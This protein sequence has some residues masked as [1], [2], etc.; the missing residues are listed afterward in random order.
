MILFD[1]FLG[2]LKVGCFAFG[3]AYGA[4]PLIRDIVLSY[5]WLSEESLTYMIAISESSPIMVNVA[6]YVG[7][8]QAGFWG[9]LVATTAVV[10][11]AFLII[12]L[13][14]V[15]LNSLL[16]RP[17][18]QAVL[19]GLKPCI[20]GIILVTGVCMLINSCIPSGQPDLRAIAVAALLIL[21]QLSYSRIRK[22][23]LTP[24]Q[25]ILVAAL[26]GICIYG[27]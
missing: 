3:G 9:A 23:N 27:I 2:F 18:V 13:V 6:T 26:A 20:I 15:M 7:S 12:L 16:S 8:S 14:M 4:I 24:I 11:P 22:K 1:L 21:V 5:G 10:L 19:R 25:L 17:P